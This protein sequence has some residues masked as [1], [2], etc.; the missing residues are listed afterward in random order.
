MLENIPCPLREDV[1]DNPLTKAE[2]LINAART[3]EDYFVAPLGNIPLEESDKLDL[4][5]VE[6][7]DRKVVDK[8]DS[9]KDSEEK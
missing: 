4:T 3:V 5:Q 8:K 7:F 6:A 2:V 1:E 9:L